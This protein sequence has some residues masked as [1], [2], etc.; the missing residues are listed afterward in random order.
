MHLVTQ[1]KIHIP[2]GMNES[3]KSEVSSPINSHTD[4][5]LERKPESSGSPKPRLKGVHHFKT[6]KALND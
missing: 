5:L 6:Y 2:A 1:S 3:L 4:S